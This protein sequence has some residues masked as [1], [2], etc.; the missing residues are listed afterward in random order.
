MSLIKQRA[1]KT[2]KKKMKNKQKLYKMQLACTKHSIQV[3]IRLTAS[4]PMKKKNNNN[5]QPNTQPFENET[6]LWELPKWATKTK[7]KMREK[8]LASANMKNLCLATKNPVNFANKNKLLVS[9]TIRTEN[10]A[11][12]GCCSTLLSIYLF[13]I[14]FSSLYFVALFFFNI[15]S[16]WTHTN[17][18][19][20]HYID[21]ETLIS[22][23][24]SGHIINYFISFGATLFIVQLWQLCNWQQ[25]KMLY[26]VWYNFCVSL[27]VLSCC[28]LL[29]QQRQKFDRKIAIGHFN[30]RLRA[31]IHWNV[32][33]NRNSTV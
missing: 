8:K 16:L 21:P 15:L 19:H 14:L 1:S 23:C 9:F 31:H 28:R 24:W 3:G 33:K 10:F 17:T 27:L 5:K 13:P 20:S 12:I 6:N 25:I 2:W 7:K 22:I 32:H 29:F 11:I 26:L 4:I 30:A 18:N